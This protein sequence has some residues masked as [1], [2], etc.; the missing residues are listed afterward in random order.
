MQYLVIKHDYT[1]AKSYTMGE[2]STRLE[3]MDMV[4]NVVFDY[5]LKKEGDVALTPKTVT[6]EK[7]TT[8]YPSQDLVKGK[9]PRTVPQCVYREYSP[10]SSSWSAVPNGHIVVRNAKESIHRLSVF[11]KVPQSGW[12]VNGSTIE[13]VFYVDIVEYELPF[14]DLSYDSETRPFVNAELIST[15]VNALKNDE[16]FTAIGQLK[17]NN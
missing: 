3:A 10:M 16:M 17:E 14:A 13:K 7:V 8:S 1:T 6:D 11:R 4:E 2:F 15:L 5:V 9:L 12:F